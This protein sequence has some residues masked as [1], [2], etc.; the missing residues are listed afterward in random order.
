M[1]SSFF[2]FFLSPSPDRGGPGDGLSLPFLHNVKSGDFFWVFFLVAY[3]GR[4]C[5][6]HSTCV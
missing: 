4:G 2:S 3:K 1:E 5:T 6:I